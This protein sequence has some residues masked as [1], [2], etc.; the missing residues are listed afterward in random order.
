MPETKDSNDLIRRSQ[1]ETEIRS[2]HSRIILA[3]ILSS[4][5]A[6]E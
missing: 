6:L 3:E 4:P 1:Y 5:V 2:A